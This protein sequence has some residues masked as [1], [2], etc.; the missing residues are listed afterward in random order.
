MKKNKAI[1]YKNLPA[2]FP[3]MSLVL[4]YML[5]LT[6]QANPYL[7][8]AFGALLILQ[9]LLFIYKKITTETVDIFDEEK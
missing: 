4:F 9:V 2:I 7:M 5:Y 6:K 8:G 1:A 3:T